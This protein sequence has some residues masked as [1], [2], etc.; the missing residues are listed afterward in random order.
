MDSPHYN[1]K[2]LFHWL[3]MCRFYHLKLLK[4]KK[5]MSRNFLWIGM[6]S[7]QVVTLCNVSYNYL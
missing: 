5:K 2:Y 4:K 3:S 6:L 7:F 1:C